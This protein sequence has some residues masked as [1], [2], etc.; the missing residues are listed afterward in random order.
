MPPVVQVGGTKVRSIKSSL[1]KAVLEKL[2]VKKAI[3]ES[4][5]LG[6]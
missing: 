1:Q 3:G 6:I 4:M 2:E 5:D